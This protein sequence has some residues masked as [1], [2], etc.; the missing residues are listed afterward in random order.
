M[1]HW[2]AFLFLINFLSN[3]NALDHQPFAHPSCFQKEDLVIEEVLIEHGL[4]ND[5]KGLQKLFPRCKYALSPSQDSII[6]SCP[7]QEQAVAFKNIIKQHDRPS[8][9]INFTLYC[10]L[11]QEQFMDDFLSTLMQ[12]GQISQKG[13]SDLAIS[14]VAEMQRKGRLTVIAA[15]KISIQAGNESVL[16]AT[17]EFYLKSNHAWGKDQRRQL[18]I[19][20]KI[21]CQAR[22]DGTFGFN[23]NMTHY[24]SP[25]G[26]GVN[27]QLNKNHLQTQIEG[28]KGDYAFLGS[29]GQW[30]T[31]QEFGQFSLLRWLPDELNPY[32]SRELSMSSQMVMLAKIE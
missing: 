1:A 26:Q 21:H 7:N 18:G 6:F 31:E 22:A 12:G 14:L 23:I 4:R 29:V 5:L 27:H 20:L 25:L 32:S 10:F 19:E 13:W 15:P 30:T 24:T 17:E 16:K 9:T 8:A 28:K 2:T 11:I 3:L